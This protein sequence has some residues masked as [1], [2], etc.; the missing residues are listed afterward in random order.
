MSRKIDIYQDPFGYGKMFKKKS[1]E[2]EPG[3]TV[4]V[5]C[6][7]YDKTTLMRI[8]KEDLSRAHVPTIS[9]DNVSEGG[10]NARSKMAFYNNFEFV[11][12][13]MCS[14]EGEN[15]VMNLGNIAREV[16][17][18]VAKNPN[19][20]ELWILLDAIDSGF[21]IDNILDVKELLFKTVL[22]DSNNQGKEIY[23]LVSANSYEMA[24][25]ERCL[26]VRS[27]KY[28]TFKTYDAY[29]KYVI[30]CSKIKNGELKA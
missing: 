17:R 5:G 22:E 27:L 15:I 23:I 7:G 9:F 1:F 18:F 14:S 25:G 21:S 28:R 20:K 6:N 11:A 10:S 3:V 16:G 2:F 4:F 13:S 24:H 8:V 19:A 30:K 29:R 12:N 26:D